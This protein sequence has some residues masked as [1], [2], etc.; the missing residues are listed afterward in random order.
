MAIIVSRL[1]N[2]LKLGLEVELWVDQHTV[3]IYFIVDAINCSSFL[4][5]VVSF[6]PVSIINLNSY[7]VIIRLNFHFIKIAI[8]LGSTC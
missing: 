6:Q 1:Q 4:V 2:V 8:C 7:L 3:Y 5:C